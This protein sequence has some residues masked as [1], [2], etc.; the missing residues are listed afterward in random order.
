MKIFFKQYFTDLNLKKWHNYYDLRL[1]M[2][3]TEAKRNNKGFIVRVHSEWYNWESSSGVSAFRIWFINT[4]LQTAL[5]GGRIFLYSKV[6]AFVLIPYRGMSVEQN[7]DG[8]H[9][10]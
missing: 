7:E 9:W 6:L 8:N 2:W 1:Q 4:M 3:E 5:L 10:I